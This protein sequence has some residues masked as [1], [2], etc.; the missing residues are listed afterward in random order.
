L[1]GVVMA[2]GALWAAGLASGY[3]WVSAAYS[4]TSAIAGDGFSA[5]ADAVGGLYSLGLLGML[6]IAAAALLYVYNVWRTFTSG[7]TTTRELLV[8]A[9]EEV[10]S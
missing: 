7:Q 2:S 1:T 5:T 9:D 10:A 8:F 4:G 6:V 3:T